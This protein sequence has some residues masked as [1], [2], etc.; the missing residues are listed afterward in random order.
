MAEEVESQ[1]QKYRA[2]VDE[3]NKRTAAGAGQDGSFDPD[4]LIR[5]NTQHLMQAVSSLPELQEQKRVGRRR[6]RAG[7]HDRDHR[8]T[9]IQTPTAALLCAPWC[10]P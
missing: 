6:A 3:I 8:L 10:A 1:L 4:E 7:E 9:V 2:A 5:R